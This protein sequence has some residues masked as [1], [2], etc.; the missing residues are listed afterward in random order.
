MQSPNVVSTVY[1]IIV[2]FPLGAFVFKIPE[3]YCLFERISVSGEKAESLR[4][5]A[6]G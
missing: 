4:A 2:P 5:L 1:S 6:V 3:I